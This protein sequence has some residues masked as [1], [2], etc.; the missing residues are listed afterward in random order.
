MLRTRFAPSPT[1]FLHIGGV[2]TALYNYLYSHRMGGQFLLRIEDTDR[3]RSTSEAVEAIINGLAWVGITHDEDIVFQG[4]RQ[5]E[6]AA[7]AERLL[8]AGKAYRCYCTKEELAERRKA[9]EATGERFKYD[10][11]C[12]D[13]T[14]QPNAPFVVR[15]KMPTGGETTIDDLI[16]G[17][18]TKPNDEFDD[19]V[20][21]RSDGVPVYHL[22]V[23][24]DDAFMEVT[25]VLRGKDHLNNTFKHIHLIMALGYD[26]PRFGHMPLILDKKGKKLSKRDAAADFSSYRKRGV[27]PEAMI[28]FLVRFGWGHK[29]QEIFSM[30]ELLEVFD[31][32]HVGRNEVVLDEGKLEWL[33]Q[34]WIKRTAVDDL[35][36]RTHD[37]IQARHDGAYA[38]FKDQALSRLE[39]VTEGTRVLFEAVKPRTHCL[40]EVVD[41]TE[42]YLRDSVEMEDKVTKFFV[43][44][45]RDLFQTLRD[46]F[47]QADEPWSAEALFG[48]LKELAES[49]DMKVGKM[50]APLRAALTGRKNS[51][52]ITDICLALGKER[53]LERLDGALSRLEG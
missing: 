21:L 42:F 33:G 4:A 35:V 43:A 12:R 50:M 32:E 47:E 6:H 27:L 53:V 39:D 8:E 1:G 25:H 3:E 23:V 16:Q 13:R 30:D 20:I 45:N 11:R 29:D 40:E 49:R 22:A 31:I 15:F 19:F 26:V 17:P 24:V 10:G 36:R 41:W 38:D 5:P 9:A 14:D 18:V 48:S 44:D 2:R 7:A 51:V 28:N 46:F 34:E 37:Y 52:G